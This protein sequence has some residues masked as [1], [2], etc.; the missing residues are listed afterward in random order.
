M[1]WGLEPLTYLLAPPP[2]ALPSHEPQVC[3]SRGPFFT[4]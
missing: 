3:V 2:Q 4:T 1:S